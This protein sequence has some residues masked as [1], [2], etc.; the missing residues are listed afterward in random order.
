MNQVLLIGNGLN[1]L[2][3]GYS[4][5]NVLLELAKNAD[6]PELMCRKDLTPFSILYEEIAV[7]SHVQSRTQE[8]E[9]KHLVARLVKKMRHNK[10]H[11]AFMEM[12]GNHVLTTNYDYNLETATSRTSRTSSFRSESRYSVFRKQTVSNKYVWHIHGEINMPDSI[13]LG[14]DHYSGQLQKLRTYATA[15]HSTKTQLK[16]PFKLHHLDFE[17]SGGTYS[18]IDVFLRDEV[19]IVGFTLD[20][21][22]IDLW[23]L[24]SYKQRLNQLSGY[25]TGRTIYYRVSEHEQSERERARLEALKSFGVEIKEHKVKRDYRDGYDQILDALSK[26]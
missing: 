16:S 12:A 19:H 26:E 6:V 13:L 11:E 21:T 14:Y 8:R 1:R 3:G 24:L 18:W 22:E 7:H 23:W 17:I 9:L 2:S 4:W 15:D 10:Y 20:Y 25:E 5:E